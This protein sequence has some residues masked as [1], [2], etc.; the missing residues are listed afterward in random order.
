MVE[1]MRDVLTH[2]GPDEEGLTIDGRIALGHRRLSIV[3]LA[4][5]H[6][7]MASDD[8]SAHLVYNG[9]VYNHLALRDGLIAA[10]HRY[11]TRCDTET[12]LRMYQQF[13]PASVE[14]LRG[15]FA[16]AIW[17]GSQ[18]QPVPCPGS[19]GHKAALLCSARGRIDL[20]RVGDQ[21]VAR[22]RRCD[23]DVERRRSAGL[24]GQPRAIGESTLFA[25]VK[26]LLPGHTLQWR[27]GQV[28]IRQYWDLKFD[29]S[30]ASPLSDAAAISE[31]GE[32][33]QDAVRSGSWPTSR[34]ACSSREGSIRQPSPRP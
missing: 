14:K 9:E 8:G 2:R 28:K 26:R 22:S 21:G 33:F 29:E 13:G 17:D 24:P 30:A 18:E 32:R 34:S 11:R 6:Q 1:R 20:L 16:F 5:G 27:D 15:M 10:G 3:D 23:A 12:V 4:A 19:A 7:P 25:G 31:F